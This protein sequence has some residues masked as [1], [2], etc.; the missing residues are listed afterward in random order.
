MLR[1]QS[2]LLN[3]INIDI[4][5]VKTG[6]DEIAHIVNGTAHN[7]TTVASTLPAMSAQVA[8]IHTVIKSLESF[9]ASSP[10]ISRTSRTG[11]GLI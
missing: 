9:T 7:I 3:T 6:L 1:L 2:T 10:K 8:E 11:Q 4:K 5:Y